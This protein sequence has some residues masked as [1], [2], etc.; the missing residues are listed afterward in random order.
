MLRLTPLR[1]RLALVPRVLCDFLDERELLPRA[2]LR[3][4]DFPRMLF[5]L[6]FPRIELCFDR[7]L[8][9]ELPLLF[10]ALAER[11]FA[12]DRFDDIFP[13]ALLRV[14]DLFLVEVV[15]IEFHSSVP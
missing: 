9:A 15:G 2:V 5:A 4:L 12:L 1:E 10:R 11:D 3:E 8:L 7:D 6:L 13:R 14:D